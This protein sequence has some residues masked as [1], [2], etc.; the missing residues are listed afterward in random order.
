MMILVREVLDFDGMIVSKPK[1]DLKSFLSL[2][3]IR[4]WFIFAWSKF[5]DSYDFPNA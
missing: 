4:G 5:M 2:K 1:L 3:I